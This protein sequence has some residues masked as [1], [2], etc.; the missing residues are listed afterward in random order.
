MCQSVRYLHTHIGLRLLAR[1]KK[2]HLQ[3]G[4]AGRQGKAR[5]VDFLRRLLK[6]G[7]ISHKVVT[8]LMAPPPPAAAGVWLCLHQRQEYHFSQ[9]N[10]RTD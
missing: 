6:V 2:I 10:F 3:D 7:T 5:S 4:P 9:S 8:L 1:K